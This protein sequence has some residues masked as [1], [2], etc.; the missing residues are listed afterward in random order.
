VV[1]YFPDARFAERMKIAK[2]QV[3]MLLCLFEADSRRKLKI[4]LIGLYDGWKGQF[5][6]DL[7]ELR[8]GRC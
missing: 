5:G 4:Y 1:T 8:N 2:E 6:R 3:D 7:P